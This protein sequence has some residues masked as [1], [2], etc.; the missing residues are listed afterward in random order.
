VNRNP[1][2]LHKYLYAN[3]NPVMFAD[4]SGQFGL[5]EL[6]VAAR[7]SAVF[8]L[9]QAQVGTSLLAFNALRYGA[10][11]VYLLN[12]LS[13]RAAE[14]YRWAVPIRL[15]TSNFTGGILRAV[16][17]HPNILRLQAGQMFERYLNP[18]MKLLGG[19]DKQSILG[20]A[21]RP[22]WIF[23]GKHI[24]DAKLGQHISFDQLAKFIQFASEKSGSI[25]YVTLTRVP[26]N[27]QQ[28]VISQAA[29]KNVSVSF[30]SLPL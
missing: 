9:A 22:D 16:K 3:A 27:L 5:L 11:A 29:S 26:P 6:G 21:A 20:G 14:A 30:I 25:T 8:L 13:V 7:N 1:V 10:P 28:Q 15:A 18:I 17:V 4:P 19:K 24:V 23:R 2:S 12:H